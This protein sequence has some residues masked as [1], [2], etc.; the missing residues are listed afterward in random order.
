MSERTETR[1]SFMDRV[2]RNLRQNGLRDTASIAW[3]RIHERFTDWR[4]GIDTRGFIDLNLGE[5]CHESEATDYR[6]LNEAFRLLSMEEEDVVL[7]DYGCGKGRT[8]AVAAMRPFKRIIGVELDEGM[9]AVARKNLAQIQWRARCRR[10]LLLNVDAAQFDVPGIV[11]AIFMFNPFSGDILRTVIAQI[12]A[13]L[14]RTPREI[15][16]F[17]LYPPET[18]SDPFEQL[19]WC[20]LL[21]SIHVGRHR[22]LRFPVYRTHCE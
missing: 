18:A 12:A 8:V 22:A 4:L 11:N 14:R 3:H 13:S 9:L 1:L 20:S 15:T 7:L 17:F 5:F 19:E 21:T 2:M 16:I 6:L 10:V